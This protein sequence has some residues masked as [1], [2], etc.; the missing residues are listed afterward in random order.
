MSIYNP[1][2][3]KKRNR[4]GERALL[5]SRSIVELIV[6]VFLPIRLIKD[7]LQCWWKLLWLW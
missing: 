2:K 5:N 7:F 1:D 6:E 4:I 3:K